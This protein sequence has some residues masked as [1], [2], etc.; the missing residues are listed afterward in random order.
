[1]ISSEVQR[2][3]VKSPPELWAEL[4]DQATLA[5]H[6]GELGEIR[7]TRVEPQRAVEWEAENIS[8]T[9]R[10]KP[11]GWGTRV[12]LT[13]TRE[14]PDP[15]IRAAPDSLVAAEPVVQDE[16]AVDETSARVD[17]ESTMQAAF[18]PAADVETEADRETE[19][20]PPMDVQA[21]TVRDAEPEPPMDIGAEA[22]PE[23]EAEPSMHVEVEPELQVG[24]EA[25][26]VL[27]VEHYEAIA[28]EP[29]QAFD[30]ELRQTRRSFFS[31]LFRRR[32]RTE[33]VEPDPYELTAVAEEPWVSEWDEPLTLL[34]PSFEPG[35]S[36]EDPYATIEPTPGALD[37]GEPLATEEAIAT[38]EPA[39]ADTPERADAE[40]LIAASTEEPVAGAAAG[41]AD[42]SAELE[43]AEQVAAE[44]VTIV[45]TAVL[46]RLGAAH[47]RPFSRA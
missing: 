40:G 2:T 17:F 26:F 27:E 30:P 14:I 25:A 31:R 19:R 35:E 23:A 34:E 41:P 37:P 46:D 28:E 39:A 3:L 8:G 10:L 21:Q 6:L 36:G 1:M 44:Q 38:E 11:S 32:P 9:V 4:S 7:I 15:T 45:L 20:K 42:L 22:V 16:P 47:H 18:E 43:A 12:T 29:V 13:V 24:P 33:P 5:R